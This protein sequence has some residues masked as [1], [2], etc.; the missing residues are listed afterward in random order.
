[1]SSAN[2]G[3]GFA[4]RYMM[5]ATMKFTGE[6]TSVSLRVANIDES[7]SDFAD[8]GLTVT[9]SGA[10]SGSAG[11]IDYPISPMPIVAMVPTRRSQVPEVQLQ[12]DDVKFTISHTWVLSQMTVMGVP[13]AMMVF[14][15]RRVMG[16]VYQGELHS[17]ESIID[18]NAG[19]QIIYWEVTTAKVELNTG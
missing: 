1:M 16:I 15:D 17:I 3:F 8:I 10:L 4:A 6:G 19:G 12:I 7:L 9:V 18:Q 5:D 11:Y 2:F 13:N 14:R